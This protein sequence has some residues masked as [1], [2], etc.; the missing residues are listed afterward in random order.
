MLAL[1]WLYI[2]INKNSHKKKFIKI[3][4]NLVLFF[5]CLFLFLFFPTGAITDTS[6][7]KADIVA[8]CFTHSIRDGSSYTS[9]YIL[10]WVHLPNLLSSWS[11]DWSSLLWNWVF[12]KSLWS[13][14]IEG[15]RGYY[16]LFFN[17]LFVESFI[18]LLLSGLILLLFGQFLLFFRF[19][20]IIVI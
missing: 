16:S 18:H 7:V 4:T 12:N 2:K 6:F 11:I 8:Y 9:L 15:I 3:H 17:G 14:C 20:F 19:I 13:V 10:H 1:G 5:G